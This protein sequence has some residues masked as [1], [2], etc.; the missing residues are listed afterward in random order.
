MERHFSGMEEEIHARDEEISQFQDVNGK[1]R[2]NLENFFADMVSLTQID[3]VKEKEEATTKESAD[4][5]IH[6]ITSKFNSEQKKNKSLVEREQTLLQ[7]N[8]KLFKKL[9]KYKE[10]LKEE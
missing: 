2:D 3:Q 10:R 6:R 5:A 7:E 9:T 8:E 4:S 1:L